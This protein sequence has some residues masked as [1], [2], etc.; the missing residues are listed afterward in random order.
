[1]PIQGSAADIIKLAM[2]RIDKEFTNRN[3][4]SKMVLQVHDELVF[5]VYL[6]EQ[7]IVRE[8]V[9]KNMENAYPFKVPLKVEIGFGSNWLEAH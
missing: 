2:I 7:K 9:E 3:L 4:K 8:I 1:M 6:P 5:D